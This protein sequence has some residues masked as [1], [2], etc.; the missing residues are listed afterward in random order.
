[1]LAARS[2]DEDSALLNSSTEGPQVVDVRQVML[3]DSKAGE[4]PQTGSLGPVLLCALVVCV[5]GVI[6]GYSHGF[7]SPTLLNLQKAYEKGER[8]TAFQ[9]S[10]I[11]AGIFG[12]S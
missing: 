9:S 5:G 10:S 6:G 2:L 4:K 7:P 3:E 8:V 1:M 11:Y 12:V